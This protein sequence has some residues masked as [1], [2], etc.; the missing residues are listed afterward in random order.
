MDCGFDISD[1]N[2]APN[3]TFKGNDALQDASSDRGDCQDFTHNNCIINNTSSSSHHHDTTNCNDCHINDINSIVSD[4]LFC[5]CE[6]MCHKDCSFPFC[7]CRKH[8]FDSASE[9]SE[10]IQCNQP[11]KVCMRCRAC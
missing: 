2:G 10:G 11:T 4:P 8:D 6:G 3:E 9:T 5:E 1:G 7:A